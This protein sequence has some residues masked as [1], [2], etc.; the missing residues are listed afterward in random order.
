MN[1]PYHL[2]PDDTQ[3]LDENFPSQWRKTVEGNGKFGLLIDD[4]PIANGYSVD[5]S[6]L[7][8]LIPIGYPGSMLDMFYFDPPLSKLNG[9]QINAL[10]SEIH[11]GRTWQ[12]WSRHYSWQPG[13]DSIIT[14][15]EYVK[16]ELY[17]ELKR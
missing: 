12:R 17:H 1:E 11:F 5:N 10:A 8:L 15:I 7:M 4:F 2:P 9:S 16:N 14:H 3:Y 6:T 13:V